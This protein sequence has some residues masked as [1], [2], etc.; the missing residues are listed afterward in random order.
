MISRRIIPLVLVCLYILPPLGCFAS[1][2]ATFSTNMH[3]NESL[4]VIASPMG[5]ASHDN[6]SDQL[7]SD[8]SD[9]DLD[10]DLDIEIKM[11]APVS[12][13]IRYLP[14]VTPLSTP[15]PL[16]SFPQVYPT[17]AIPPPSRV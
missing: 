11:L 12:S 14:N 4:M 1:P 9:S 15:E 2:Q 17:I 13:M 16:L 7:C 5:P 3:N 8:D 10:F 6:S